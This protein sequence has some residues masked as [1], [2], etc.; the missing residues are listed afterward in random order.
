MFD[1]CEHRHRVSTIV[2]DLET[3]FLSYKDL[4]GNEVIISPSKVIAYVAFASPSLPLGVDKLFLAVNESGFSFRGDQRIK[5]VTLAAKVLLKLDWTYLTVVVPDDKKARNEILETFTLHDLCIAR[6]IDS[7]SFVDNASHVSLSELTK[8][9]PIVFL[10]DADSTE[11]VLDRVISRSGRSKLTYIFL[12]WNVQVAYGRSARVSMEVAILITPRPRQT[13]STSPVLHDERVEDPWEEEFVS[14]S[15]STIEQLD[16]GTQSA[17]SVSQAVGSLLSALD[18]VYKNTCPEQ[19]GVCK[20]FTDLSTVKTKVYKKQ[21]KD[22]VMLQVLALRP[23]DEDSW[24]E[25][26]VWRIYENKDKHF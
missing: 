10:T 9:R 16:T 26:Q 11:S 19:D 15:N 25:T 24:T 18:S 23:A 22:S 8:G 14:H 4:S 7:K 3:C 20:A 13:S 5:F 17:S 12:P 21:Q 6:I 1:S 2:R